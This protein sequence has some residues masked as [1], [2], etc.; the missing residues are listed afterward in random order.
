MSLAGTGAGLSGLVP[1]YPAVF[2]LLLLAGFGIAMFH[3]PS[4]RDAR[5]A[6]GNSATAMSWFAAGGSVGFFVGPA[7]VTPALDTLG[8][9][10][11]APAGRVA[12]F[13]EARATTFPGLSGRVTATRWPVTLG[14]RVGL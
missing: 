1:S 10:A 6:A 9:G 8:L 4:G 3:P 7:L 2:A 11:S 12:P 5:R 14:A 13:V